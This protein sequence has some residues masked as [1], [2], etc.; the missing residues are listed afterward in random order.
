M[1]PPLEIRLLGPMAVRRD[2]AEVKLPGS[3]KV[4]A[5][6]AYLALSSQ[7]PSRAQLCDLLWD[8]PD[9]P[10]GELRWCLS[11]VRS[12]I[13][14]QRVMVQGDGIA[15]DLSGCFVDAIETQSAVKH[16]FKALSLTDLRKLTALFVGDFLDGLTVDRSPSF[17]TWLAAQRR[18]FRDIHAALLEQLAQQLNPREALVYLDRWIQLTPFDLRPHEL[19]LTSLAASGHLREGE[20]HVEATA[21]LFGSEG[22]E[23]RPIREIWNAARAQVVEPTMQ[24]PSVSVATPTA[25]E[26]TNSL[27]ELRRA[28][29]AIMPF[30]DTSAVVTPG[31]PSDALSYDIITRLAKLRSLK[32]IAQGTMFALRERRH[33]VEEVATLLDV[34]YI[35]D[36]LFERRGNRVI[37]RVELTEARTARIVWA[38]VFDHNAAETLIL[39]EEIGSRIVVSIDREVET[40]ERNRAMLKPPNSL[41][42]WEAHHRGLWHMYRFTRSDNAQAQHFFEKAIGLDP[43]F[44][45]AHAG[46]SFTHF[47]NAFQH[48]A[49]R[50]VEAE[51]A[52]RAANQSMMADDR[53]P[54]AHLAIGRAHWLKRA[55]EQSV[56]ELQ[57]AIELSP[58][59]ATAHYSLAFVQSQSGDAKA[60][61]AAADHSRALSP[62]DP[63]LFAMLASR[64]LALVRLGNFMEAADWGVKAAARPNAHA[65]I[66]AIAAI[67]L[68]LAARIQEGRACLGILLE[69]FPHYRLSDFLTAFHL[70]PDDQTVFCKGARQI[71]LE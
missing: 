58:S 25:Y 55:H 48:W 52:Y 70:A 7:P 12:L 63:L 27:R 14:E 60:A 2:G 8:L 41:D 15:L 44:A 53:D 36:G 18:R 13:G 57:Q 22:V 35:V 19:L 11:K 50:D 42:A 20:E 37:V 31:G 65:H 33:T 40:I 43:T 67:C 49:D 34:D 68:S 1:P 29:I 59:F 54:T 10:R 38:E 51:L 16:N 6:L 17:Q 62:F 30:T 32:V 64:A 39:L 45:R 69:R 21:R 66:L 23:D 9:D 28:S 46:L 24:R 26:P 4:R 56:S 47:Q 5:L 71:G 3:R 61:I